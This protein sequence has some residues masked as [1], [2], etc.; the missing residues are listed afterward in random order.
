MSDKISLKADKRQITGHKVNRLRRE[1]LIPANL[2]GKGITSESIQVNFKEFETVFDKAGETGIITLTFD[3][4]DHPVLVSDIHTHP[5]SGD[6]LHVDFRQV[7]LK[8]K[9]EAAV[10]VELIGESPAEKAG[11]TVVLMVDEIEVEALP[12]DLP[13]KFEIDISMLTEAGQLVHVKD[14]A[15]DASKVEVK[16][17]PEMI[18]VKVEEPQKEV[19]IEEPVATEGET[20]AEGE[21]PAEGAETK[22]EG[23]T[24]ETPAEA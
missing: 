23:Q 14:L 3:G 9:I 12:A 18:V 6:P 17:D 2:F 13:E 4:K 11:N 16:T 20:P 24:E 19:V 10:P 15:V 21:K 5:V 22:E 8:E 7:N 1:G